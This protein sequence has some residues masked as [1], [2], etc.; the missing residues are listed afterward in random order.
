[1]WLALLLFVVI[2][3]LFAYYDTRKPKNFPPGMFTMRQ[4]EDCR[5]YL[6]T[7]TDLGCIVG[8]VKIQFMILLT[9]Y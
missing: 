9:G 3:G 2:L 7:Q 4:S 8:P 1:M 6:H 5:Y